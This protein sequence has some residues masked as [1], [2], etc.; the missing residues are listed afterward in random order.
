MSA[1]FKIAI[2]VGLITS[3]GIIIFWI[4]GQLTL[5]RYLKIEYYAAI[6]AVSFLTAGMV[7]A[8]SKSIQ[9]S[10]SG[11]KPLDELTQKELSILEQI[12]AGKSNKEIAAENF[13]ELS[14]IKTHINNIYSKLSVNSRKEAIKVYAGRRE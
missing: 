11:K 7:M 9:N 6:I 4:I 5:Y 3:V 12:A 1:S 2:R 10:P 14:T 13:V 8:R